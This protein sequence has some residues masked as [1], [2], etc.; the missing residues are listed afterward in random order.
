MRILQIDLTN[1]GRFQGFSCPL[2]EGFTVVYGENEAGKSTIMDFL[3]LV[4]YGSSKRRDDPREYIRKRYIGDNDKRPVGVLHFEQDGKR[5]RLTRR[6]GATNGKDVIQ[7]AEEDTGKEIA[8]PRKQSVGEWAFGLDMDAFKRSVYIGST[9]TVLP[10]VTGNN[11]DQLMSR[12]LNLQTTG[13]E[14]TSATAVAKK[15][16]DVEHQFV[17]SRGK[18]GLL[19]EQEERI[20]ALQNTR[21][22]ALLQEEEMRRER[23]ALE[24]EQRALE[25]CDRDLAQQREELARLQKEWEAGDL[26][27]AQSERKKQQTMREALIRAKEALQMQ[28]GTMTEERWE[29][30]NAAFSSWQAAASLQ[31]K[32]GEEDEPET[33]NQEALTVRR[34]ALVR[35]ENAL[36]AKKAEGQQKKEQLERERIILEQQRLLAEE[37]LQQIRAERARLEQEEAEEKAHMVVASATSFG[38]GALRFLPLVLALVFAVLGYTTSS[39]FYGAAAMV[40]VFG[41]AWLLLASRKNREEQGKKALFMERSSRRKQTLSELTKKEATL[42]PEHFREQE[43]VRKQRMEELESEQAA[44][45]REEEALSRAR[46]ALEEE[47]SRLR[48]LQAKREERNKQREELQACCRKEQQKLTTL[49]ESAAED[50]DATASQISLWQER[51]NAKKQLAWTLSREEKQFAESFPQWADWSLADLDEAIAKE[52]LSTESDPHLADRLKDAQQEYAAKQTMREELA[53]ALAAKQAKSKEKY[54]SVPLADSLL[55]TLHQEEEKEEQMKEEYQA[56]QLAQEALQEATEKARHQ[57]SPVLNTRAS[58]IFQEISGKD[59]T[60]RVDTDMD[61]RM[62]D[63]TF[64]GFLDWRV[65]STGTIDQAYFSL[66]IALAEVAAEKQDLP[67]FFDDAFAYY[68]DRRAERAMDFLVQYAKEKQK[69][70]L[71]FTAHR[72]FLRWAKDKDIHCISLHDGRAETEENK[73]GQGAK[74]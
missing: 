10:P 51:L 52:G 28:E 67:L 31:E 38:R 62:E 16:Q 13:E 22:S 74:A 43:T 2:P 5:Y 55:Q 63:A 32:N 25:A 70:I 40:G 68:D 72:R 19:F 44:W 56:V 48:A 36:Q 57:F 37:R 42:S 50:L 53:I 20:R 15:L 1:F 71:L 60:L 6:F 41:I 54:K 17:K 23:Q 26:R 7:L 12:L 11:G 69:Q 58:A 27:R 35:K 29:E 49:L 34:D 73:T 3:Q 65:L 14:T 30:A 61:M 59:A 39:L 24:G 8:L 21:N 18:G 33:E 9:G 45:M 66:R 47:E 64:P 46:S 4:F